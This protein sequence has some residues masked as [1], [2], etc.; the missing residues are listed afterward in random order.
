VFSVA[1][2][3]VVEGDVVAG[4]GVG[5]LVTVTRFGAGPQQGNQEVTVSTLPISGSDTAQAEDFTATT[6]VV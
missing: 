1:D 4:E 3:T 2:V 5:V 6:N